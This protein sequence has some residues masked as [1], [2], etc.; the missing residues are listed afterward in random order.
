MEFNYDLWHERHNECVESVQRLCDLDISK[1]ALQH[2]VKCNSTLC[3]MKNAMLD[4]HS[5]FER[6][7]KSAAELCFLIRNIDV[8][9]TG[10]LDINNLLFGIGL[11]KPEKAIERC[12]TDKGIIC[13]FRTLR[14][15]ILAHPVDTFFKNDSGESETIYLEDFHPFNPTIDAFII[16]EKC[17]YVKVMCK[18]ESHSSFF[19]PLLIDKDIIPVINTL[20]A[21]IELLTQNTKKQIL[22]SESN[23]SKQPLVLSK[24]SMR[25]YII[26]LDKELERRYP[27]AIEN[28]EYA[29]GASEHYSIVYQC[30]MYFDMNFAKETQAKYELFLE[31]IKGELR[32]IEDDLR[33]MTF[34]EDNYFGLLYNYNFAPTMSYEKTKMEYLLKSDDTSYTE[35]FIGNDTISNKLWGIRCFRLLMPYIS[36][37]IPVDKSVSDKGL[38]CQFLAAEYLSNIV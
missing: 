29:N 36:K 23:F 2:S 28:I 17:D 4:I 33:Q 6:N 26:S 20:I 35:E 11:N 30:L 27:S 37:Y 19:E 10:I 38:Y 16:K 31:Y 5:Y 25:N 1:V 22:L 21:S 15:M 12:F 9:V 32:K 14:S 8:I 34:N 24:D 13:R 7:V 3:V 18:P